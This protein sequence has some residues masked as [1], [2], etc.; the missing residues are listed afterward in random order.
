MNSVDSEIKVPSRT[1]NSGRDFQHRRPV[2]MSLL[3]A[4]QMAFEALAVGGAGFLSLLIVFREFTTFNLDLYVPSII[5][6]AAIYVLISDLTGSY[7]ASGQFSL[8]EAWRRT[9]RAWMMT[10]FLVIA[11]GFVL[12]VSE[13]FSRL[14]AGSWFVTGFISVMS[15]RAVTTLWS[16]RLRRHGVFDQRVAIYGASEQGQ[17]LG[18]YI[19]GHD[20]LV[21]SIVGFY[22]ERGG[23]RAPAEVG[24]VPMRGRLAELVADIRAGEIDQVIV[25]LPWAAEGRL[26][27]VVGH[28][29]LTPVR[30]RLAP[31]LVNFAFSH[32]P[33][34]LL[35][36]VPV[37]TLFDR[38]IS[39]A[40]F[41]VKWLEDKLLAG[42]ILALIW[43]L[44]LLVAILIKLDSPGPIFFRQPR[45]GYNNRSFRVWKFRSM[46]AEHCESE[47]ITQ[48][49]RGDPRIT[50]LGA[51]LRRTSIDELPQFFNVLTGEMSIVG[52]R[53]HAPSTRAGDKLFTEVVSSYAARHRV[54]P[55]ITGWAQ[56]NG[57][58]GETDTE[59]KLLRR[60]EHDLYYIENWSPMFDLYIVLRTIGL[61]LFDRRAF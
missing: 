54:K 44:L 60:L 31:D 1:E 51:I 4:A 13:G 10:A 5:V 49:Q 56:V 29:A 6:G 11:L 58:R 36:E 39:G 22:D 7:E 8:I 47:G 18:R 37:L 48:A 40:N 42:A 45:E 50:R 35:G 43:P 21:I 53:P 15:V 20:K 30:I 3:T 34:M 61:V 12:K 57:W 28:L 32:R 25:A 23:E 38:P 2:P 52:P 46:R 41:V 26:Q 17:K 27:E 24:G 33:V 19:Q 59:E 16:N 9:T 14:W 55:G